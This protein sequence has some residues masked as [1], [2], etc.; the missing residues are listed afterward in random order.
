M[1]T[2]EAG[3]NLLLNP[4]TEQDYSER[5]ASF[6]PPAKYENIFGEK[7]AEKMGKIIG[8]M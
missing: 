7:V 1:E 5:I 6:E 8:E 2:V 4:L 3:W